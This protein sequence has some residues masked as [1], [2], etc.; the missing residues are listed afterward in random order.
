VSCSSATECIA[1]GSVVEA[2]NGTKWAIEP[3]PAH[4]SSLSGV[5]CTSA[6]ACTAVGSVV[7][8][9]NGK[10]WAIEPTPN[11]TGASLL[12][13]SCT[14]A[15]ACTAVGSYD[16]GPADVTAYTAAHIHG[17]LA[18]AWNGKRWAVQ[19]TPNP[20]GTDNSLT[21]VSCR[22]ATACTAVGY[23]DGGTLAEAWNGRVW[24]IELTPNPTGTQKTGSALLGVSCTSA[25]T[26]TAVGS[27][28]GG[29]LAEAWNGKVWAIEP[30]PNPTGSESGS[31]A[32]VSCASTTA[33]A[34]V[35]MNGPYGTLAEAW[36]G[37]TWTIEPTPNPSG[38]IFSQLAGVSCTSAKTCTAV[39]GGGH[40]SAEVWNGQT[41]AIKPTPNPT[42]SESGSLSGVSCT[43]VTACTAVGYYL[44]S[45]NTNLTLAEAWNGKTWTIETTPNP[46]G[47][48]DLYGV[49][50][51]SATACTAVGAS[52]LRNYG[53]TNL[54][55]AEAWNGRTWTIEPTPNP[56]GS[57][58]SSLYAV[59]CSSANACTAV[60]TY[61]SSDTARASRTLVE[62]WD[63]EKWAIETSPNQNRAQVPQL[64]A[65][66]CTSP[67]AC[68]AVGT[69][70]IGADSH[71]LVEAWN[72]KK[73]A[74]ETTPNPT[75]A[76]ET[77]L[78]GVSCTSTAA[79][80][81]VGGYYDNP[82]DD[83]P[84]VTLVE[85]WNGKRWAITPTPNPNGASLSEVSCTSAT[86]CAAVGS[87]P[88]GP[89]AEIWNGKRWAVE[90]VPKPN[91]AFLIGVSCTSATACIA[92]GNSGE[93]TLAERFS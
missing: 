30:T 86:A 65:V 27:G 2:W 35:G 16:N 72:G 29:T 74:I 63:G 18:E 5:S 67:S 78:S 69:Y 44:N 56:N 12:G 24:A 42:G 89:L 26:C 48:G 28:P 83:T 66:S 38:G 32:G 92:V 11:P 13:V 47:I 70:V 93:A 81:A 50:C 40:T 36:N 46:K 15:K 68:T 80:T 49:S 45:S 52:G 60:G 14:S 71:M 9:W 54:T 7:E 43:S 77:V 41:W 87:G 22:S 20:S 62:A 37:K 51:I 79:C 55:L 53:N 57:R 4:Y 19:P 3:T 64:S 61:K 84:D 25:S 1:V 39:G 82:E 75:G 85:A 31:L 88:K 76:Q 23:D 34:A 58:E 21:A 59:S 33:C 17:T 90:R 8:A 91:R 6:T 10:T 73:W